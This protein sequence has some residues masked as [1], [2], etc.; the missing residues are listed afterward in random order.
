MKFSKLSLPTQKVDFTRAPAQSAGVKHG[1]PSPKPV[2]PDAGPAGEKRTVKS[3][4]AKSAFPKT[5]M[6]Y[7]S[8]LASRTVQ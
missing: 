5:R 6:K 2:P 4:I 8:L 3:G 7:R 1:V